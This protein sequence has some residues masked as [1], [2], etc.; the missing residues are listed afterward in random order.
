[1]K[2]KY[3]IKK[4]DRWSIQRRAMFNSMGKRCICGKQACFNYP[5]MRGGVC[6]KGCKKEGMINVRRR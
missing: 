6:C 4:E 3:Y 1:M 5:S 2:I